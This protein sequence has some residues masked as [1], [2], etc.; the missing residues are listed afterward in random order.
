MLEPWIP[1]HSGG[2][3]LLER[4]VGEDLVRV[5]CERQPDGSWMLTRERATT[6][7][8]FICDDLYDCLDTCLRIYRPDG[9]PRPYPVTPPVSR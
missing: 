9:T 4:G 2:P 8:R 5:T 3:P 7:E 1:P 6:G